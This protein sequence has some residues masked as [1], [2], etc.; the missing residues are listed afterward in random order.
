MHERGQYREREG[1]GANVEA[2]ISVWK[3]AWPGKGWGC[4][5]KDT[6]L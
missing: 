5:R 1:V 2:K 4:A 6:S 3:A